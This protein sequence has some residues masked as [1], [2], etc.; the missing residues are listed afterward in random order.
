MEIQQKHINFPIK[1]KQQR[2]N[3]SGVF[4]QRNMT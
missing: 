2:P 4:T 3:R 1:A